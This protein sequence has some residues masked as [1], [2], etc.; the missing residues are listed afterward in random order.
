MLELVPINA[1]YKFPV[2]E[3]R[4]GPL[5]LFSGGVLYG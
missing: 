5:Y 4:K 2:T 3:R 1:S